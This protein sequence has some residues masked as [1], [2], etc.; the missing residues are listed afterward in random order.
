M[1]AGRIA[2]LANLAMLV[3]GCTQF[4]TTQ[5]N[6]DRPVRSVTTKPRP[7]SGWRYT[8]EAT[9]E[10]RPGTAETTVNLTVSRGRMCQVE[11]FDEVERTVV[12]KRKPKAN[13]N[14]I[15]WEYGLGIVG[16]GLTTWGAVRL[17][18]GEPF[19]ETNSESVGSGKQA[20]A[21]ALLVYLGVPMT[22][23]LPA[24]VIDSVQAADSEER[25]GT[26]QIDK[27][28]EENACDESPAA[29]VKVELYTTGERVIASGKTDASGRAEL[30]VVTDDVGPDGVRAYVAG[31]F[32]A[33]LTA[34]AGVARDKQQQAHAEA[35]ATLERSVSAVL[36]GEVAS[37]RCTNQRHAAAM[38]LLGSYKQMATSRGFIYHA[39]DVVVATMEGTSVDVSGWVL[40]GEL[41]VFAST[42]LVEV[43]DGQDHI[44][45]VPVEV[46]LD[47]RDS[48]GYPS[49]IKSGWE[50]VFT[51]NG[52]TSRVVQL[53]RGEQPSVK[54]FGKG[55]T[56]VVALE[57][58][59]P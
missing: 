58:M 56:L 9:G 45:R 40:S 52:G 8:V 35:K 5:Q 18:G 20:T 50:G 43:P 57:H 16:A 1:R 51:G 4:D 21:G 26:V 59:G 41:H 2:V 22:L 7:T 13:H 10:V 19:S 29:G 46:R 25:V 33:A 38:E 47:A 27:G 31:K 30:K 17:A 53:R 39:H 32:A 24:G 28:K 11:Q 12:T 14:W 48:K 54:V 42:V 6:I 36:D 3:C 37:G 34:F 55:C 49:K 15:P 23:F 44:R